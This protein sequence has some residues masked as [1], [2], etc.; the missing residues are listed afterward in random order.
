MR[1]GWPYVIPKPVWT[2]LP[3]YALV[4]HT[5]SVVR[6]KQSNVEKINSGQLT[7]DRPLSTFQLTNASGIF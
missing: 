6:T 3:T 2:Q 5:T 7:K 4:K 1:T